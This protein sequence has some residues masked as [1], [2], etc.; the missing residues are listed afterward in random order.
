MTP[1]SATRRSPPSIGGDGAW[2]DILGDAVALTPAFTDSSQVGCTAER[3][4][5][6]GVPE[7]HRRV[8]G[9]TGAV[10]RAASRAGCA[11]PGHVGGGRS[12]RRPRRGATP[13]RLVAGPGNRTARRVGRCRTR[14]KDGFTRDMVAAAV[15][16]PPGRMRGQMAIAS[17]LVGRLP[18]TLDLLRS[19]QISQRHA[20]EL[21]DATRSLTPETAAVVEARVLERA[22]EQTV[23][24]FRASVKRAV[25]R[26]AVPGRGRQGPCRCGGA[27]AGGHHPGRARHGRTMGLPAR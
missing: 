25:L 19:G 21:A 18:A 13:H 24:Q 5:G 15:R 20:T 16:V 11:H 9:P 12:D 14:R 17:D 8:P 2:A 10:G 7:R 6:A 4:R 26:V 27:A 1:W 22:P 3:D 23:T